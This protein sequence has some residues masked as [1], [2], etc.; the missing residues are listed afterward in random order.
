MK[1]MMENSLI[2][3]GKAHLVSSFSSSPLF[4]M[5]L[6]HMLTVE[7]CGCPE[8]KANL[9]L[10]PTGNEEGKGHV[11][12]FITFE[13]TNPNLLLE[14]KIAIQITGQKEHT[15]DDIIEVGR[16]GKVNFDWEW[17]WFKFCEVANIFT[18]PKTVLGF[19][20]TVLRIVEYREN[21]EVITFPVG[22]RE[23]IFYSEEEAKQRKATY[24]T[25]TKEKSKQQDKEVQNQKNQVII[26]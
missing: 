16:G 21:N 18:Q 26:C 23:Y 15:I 9:S 12:A 5:L 20:V 22:R 1:I 6:S 13:S 4:P 25:E 3:S 24:E 14:V 19:T 17:G 2:Y 8:A 10:Y 11:S 7:L